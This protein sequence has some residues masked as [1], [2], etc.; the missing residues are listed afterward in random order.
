MMMKLFGAITRTQPAVEQSISPE[1]Y[2]R[3]QNVHKPRSAATVMAERR[4]VVQPS[5][6]RRI[7]VPGHQR[8]ARDASHHEPLINE[9][10]HL[11]ADASVP[12]SIL[13]KAL[14]LRFARMN[15]DVDEFVFS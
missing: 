9:T 4:A 3:S 7:A 5:T 11:H 13:R 2:T 8:I 15:R 14:P 12:V 1:R 6:G 10:V